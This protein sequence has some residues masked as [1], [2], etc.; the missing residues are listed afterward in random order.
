MSLWPLFIF[1]T[2]HFDHPPPHFFLTTFHFDYLLL[3]SVTSDVF[4]RSIFWKLLLHLTSNDQ[5]LLITT[6]HVHNLLAPIEH[7]QNWL[8]TTERVHTLLV[9]TDH[10]HSLLVPPVN[11]LT[12]LSWVQEVLSVPFLKFSLISH[13]L[14]TSLEARVGRIKCFKWSLH[15]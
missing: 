1:T 9:P 15:R 4:F 5:T 11:A 7:A 3:S 6:E 2:F 12:L 14:L 8:I 13:I 10:A